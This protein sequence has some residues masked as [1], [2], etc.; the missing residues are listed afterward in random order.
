MDEGQLRRDFDS[1]GYVVVPRALPDDQVVRLRAAIDAAALQ[2]DSANELSL[3]QMRFVSN[4]YRMSSDAR[5]IIAGSAIA[6]LAIALKGG[7]VWVRWDQAV[8]KAPG[9]PWFPWHQDNG[10]SQLL[11]EHIQVWVALG[12]S[13]T[14][15]GGL[16]LIPGGH[17]EALDH[18]WRGD[19]VECFEDS[20]AVHRGAVT[21]DADA[22]DIVVF[23]SML[24]HATGPHIEGP[25]RL[26]YVVEFLAVGESDDSVP[27]PHFRCTK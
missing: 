19:H 11:D 25:T 16:R 1:D 22:G 9:A 24:P 15:N 12:P 13:N 18:V 7:D 5:D 2:D 20:E 21:V 17:R 23:S 27:P 10:Y 8:W 14:T 26:A 3:G 4:V 6:Q